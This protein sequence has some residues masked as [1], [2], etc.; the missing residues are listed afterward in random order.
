MTCNRQKLTVLSKKLYF[1]FKQ[2]IQ[3]NQVQGKF[4]SVDSGAMQ[5]H[6][7]STT[8]LSLASFLLISFPHALSYIPIPSMDLY[9]IFKQIIP[10]DISIN[11]ID[12]LLA[13]SLQWRGI[14]SKFQTSHFCWINYN[15]GNREG[16]IWVRQR[17]IIQIYN[18]RPSMIF[19]TPPF[20]DQISGPWCQLQRNGGNGFHPAP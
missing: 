14:S 19:R 20:H 16:F 4:S 5:R 6:I 11:K 1:I 7:I 17:G 15:I 9:F 12:G 13:F 18:S 10:T 8:V 2:I 3:T